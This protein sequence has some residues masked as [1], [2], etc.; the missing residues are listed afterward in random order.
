MEEFRRH[1]YT[2]PQ[3][4]PDGTLR[5][6]VFHDYGAFPVWGRF[7]APSVRDRPRRELHGMLNPVHLGISTGLAADLLA[8]STWIDAHSEW[9]GRHPATDADREAHQERGRVLADRL[10]VET[11]AEVLFCWH[12]ADGD[13]D[14]PHCG[15]RARTYR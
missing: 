7:T 11:G 5:L 12:W 9:S 13:P 2:C 6:D 4:R 10:A 3:A 14:C 1:H 8:W 15:E